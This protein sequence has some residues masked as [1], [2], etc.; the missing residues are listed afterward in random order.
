MRFSVTGSDNIKRTMAEVEKEHI[1]N[2][3]A[4][5]KNNKSQAA[6]ILGIDRK[7]LREKIKRYSL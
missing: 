7:T 3:L 6:A 2:V 4:Y 5:T 1:K